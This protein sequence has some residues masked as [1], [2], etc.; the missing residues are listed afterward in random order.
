MVVII[1]TPHAPRTTTVKLG[2][3]DQGRSVTNL[4]SPASPSAPIASADLRILRAWINAEQ[5]RPVASCWRPQ[6]GDRPGETWRCGDCGPC[7]EHRQTVVAA[8][9]TAVGQAQEGVGR[10][11][12][13]KF[14]YR[15]P[16]AVRPLLGQPREEGLKRLLG[17]WVKWERGA[18]KRLSEARAAGLE[19]NLE[20]GWIEGY[21]KLG[22]REAL[23]YWARIR[24]Q[25][26]LD[27][28]RELTEARD[29]HDRAK[30]TPAATVYQYCW[31]SRLKVLTAFGL[32]PSGSIEE[33][34]DALDG[35]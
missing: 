26:T 15:I 18:G 3:F 13:G 4:V 16:E 2:T 6:P 1:G 30:W 21:A 11:V 33:E 24:G 28:Q 5:A 7:R 25:S 31:R 8:V 19:V 14:Y 32:S 20:T 27:I 9:E 23:A 34:A 22:E 29:L 12:L 35:A 10:R 17:C